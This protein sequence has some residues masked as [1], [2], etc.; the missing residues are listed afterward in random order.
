MRRLP[1]VSQHFD[2]YL[3]KLRRKL[4]FSVTVAVF[5]ILYTDYLCNARSNSSYYL[6]GIAIEN[7]A[8]P[9]SFTQIKTEQAIDY[10]RATYYCAKKC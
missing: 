7:K 2:K 1:S 5:L 6:A 9:C 8:L 10:L 3:Q 4:I